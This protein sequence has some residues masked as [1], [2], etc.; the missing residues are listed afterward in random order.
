MQAENF[1]QNIDGAKVRH[2]TLSTQLNAA[3][4]LTTRLVQE[5]DEA[6][7]EVSSWNESWENALSKAGLPASSDVGT[8]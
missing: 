2:D 6:K 5:V 3:Q 7:A 4:T 8:V 1:I